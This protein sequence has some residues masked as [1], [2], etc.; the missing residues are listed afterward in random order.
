MDASSWRPVALATLCLVVVGLLVSASPALAKEIHVYGA[1]FGEHVDK[2]T[3]GNICTVASHDVCQPGE[4]GS[5]PGQFSSPAGVAVNA[6]TEPLTQPAAGDVYVVDKGNDRVER[7]S[8][9]GAYLGQFDGSG[10][11]EVE[12]KDEAGTPAPTG[13]FGE[14]EA[15]AVDNS[16]NPLDPSAGDVYVSDTGHSV[17][18]KFSSKGAYLG[19]LAKGE[20]GN[21]FGPLEGLA[22]DPAGVVWV[23]QR[24][25]EE[26]AEIDAFTD[27]QP[28]VFASSRG[29]AAPGNVEPGF[30]VDAED[31]LYVDHRQVHVVAKLNSAGEE[32]AD[33]FGGRASVSG[34]TGVAVDASS[35]SVFLDDGSSVTVLTGEESL[36]DNFGAGQLAGGSGVGVNSSSA[37]VYA[38]DAV[39]NSVDIFDA[40]TL[41]DVVTEAPTPVTGTKAVLRGTVNPDG[42]EV[43]S[44]EFEWGTEA[45]VYPNTAA[46][47]PAPGSGTGAVAVSAEITGLTRLVNFHYRLAA[48]NATDKGID[49]NGQDQSFTT[50]AVDA[51]STGSAEEVTART[52]KLTGSLSPDGLDAHYY[53]EYSTSETPATTASGCLEG[54]GCFISPALPGTDAGSGSVSVPAETQLAGL[55]AA[56]TYHYR[57]VGVNSFG[58][59][60]GA[61]A[62]FTTLPLAVITGET[63][64]NVSATAADLNAQIDPSGLA[65]TN[66]QFEIGTSTSYG[67]A[68]ACEP[69]PGAGT[70]DVHVTAHVAELVKNTTYHW[71]VRDTDANGAATGLDH[72]FIY[73]ETGAGLPD[74]RAYEMVTPP[75]KNGALIN[76]SFAGVPPGIAESGSR[77][78]LGSVQCFGNAESCSAVRHTIGSPYEFTRTAGG[79]ATS[80]LAPPATEF[81]TNSW[82]LF[83]ADAGTGLFTAPTAPDG[84]DDWYARQAGGSFEDVGPFTPPSGG[85]NHTAE[86]DLTLGFAATVDLSHIVWNSDPVW[87]GSTGERDSS[88]VE[89]TSSGSTEPV[90]IGVSGKGA[91]N[92]DLISQCA[93][94]LAGQQENAMSADG[95]LVYFRALP[96]NSTAGQPC[97][98]T[99]ANESLNVTVGELYARVDSGEPDAHTVAISEPLAPQTI[100]STPPDEACTGECR[101]DITDTNGDSNWRS[102][103]FWGASSDGSK[104]F[105]TSAQRLT[106]TATEAGEIGV[107]ECEKPSVGVPGCNLYEYEGAADASGGRLVDVSAGDTSGLGP[108]V[109]GVMGVASD[110]SH[111]Y[112]VAKGVLSSAANDQGQTAQ[113]EQD[114]LYV[115][116]RDEAH[117]TGRLAFIAALPA[118]DSSAPETSESGSPDWHSTDASPNVT[119]D[120]RF[121]VFTSRGVLT[122]DVTRSDGARAVFRYD[123][124]T[125]Q[126][127]RISIGE[128]GFND[129]GN[130]GSGEASIVPAY[131]GYLRT[132]AGRP[133]PTMSNDGSRVFFMSPVALTPGAL[134]SAQIDTCTHKL[135][136]ER[137]HCVEG[138]RLL[139]QNVYEWERAGTPG[140]SCPQG[141]PGGACVFLISDGHDTAFGISCD[142]PRFS[143]TCLIGPDESGKNVFFESADQLVPQDTDTQLDAYDARIC[144]PEQGNPCIQ[145][146]A[147][148]PPP[149]QGEACHGIPP[150]RS[151]FVP[152]P[153]AT[154]NGVGNLLSTPAPPVKPKPLTRAQKLA[155][156]L[157]ACR[158]DKKKAKRVSCERQ[159]RRKYGPS[160][161]KKASNDQRTSS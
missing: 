43:S 140:G 46:C 150:A 53:F 125:G 108:R 145:P 83:S 27:Q 95:R 161:A 68:L 104:A 141:A 2:T 4:A 158:K 86:T 117:P 154:F 26:S 151:P 78:I 88:L 6:S 34:V 47:V 159:A 48:T 51:L 121:L 22:V 54:L 147:P 58:A 35:S 70:A 96:F 101:E 18:D 62:T 25:A 98:G 120:G 67:Q 55:D 37:T 24:R 116:E 36:L 114:N 39:A 156:A 132:G 28:N 133:D 73:D 77:V 75:D 21:A 136:E 103:Q 81:A 149:C 90:F 129:N 124:Q 91:A 134:S 99:G 33:E 107:E 128:N 40:L 92:K 41:P 45:G 153:S 80:A 130:G 29:S 52:A 10:A 85:Q 71:R 97:S 13:A 5:A 23:Y 126:L 49:S 155:A 105:F 8:A 135:V 31:N 66:C 69:Q 15:V 100:S 89:Y 93:A 118:S 16:T 50:P 143:A 79:W 152:G 9:T 19:Q 109:Q 12:G 157:K 74:N 32:L 3:N 57:L 160:K 137:I 1:S 63:V 44:C 102:A 138:S 65:T 110:G 146:P 61:D 113:E 82:W 87:P 115:Y 20:G 119:P 14:P 122:P 144:E 94:L 17:V 60:F 64:T 131:R 111:V 84:E 59:T 148:T 142:E 127:S 30:A 42:I 56:A 76:D 11:F 72:T 106:N 7:F 123:A 139:A 112:F 38:A